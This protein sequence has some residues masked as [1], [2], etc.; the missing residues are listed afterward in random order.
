MLDPYNLPHACD[1]GFLR[2]SSS[3]WT[4]HPCIVL[5]CQVRVVRL[6]VIRAVLLLLLLL[7]HHL[8]R[9][10]W[11]AAGATAPRALDRSGRR[12]TERRINVAWPW[13]LAIPA[14]CFSCFMFMFIVRGHR[15]FDIPSICQ[16]CV[17]TGFL[18]SWQSVCSLVVFINAV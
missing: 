17:A 16:S 18:V 9:E 7:C 13:G 11:N 5:P 12:R 10:P 6:D 8:N 2:A 15:C 3:P 4:E 1:V 14:T